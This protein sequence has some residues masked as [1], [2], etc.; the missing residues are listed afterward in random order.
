MKLLFEQNISFRLLRKIE[1]QYP[2]ARQV[3]EVGLEDVTD[4]Q[5]W[6]YARINKF[7][8]VTFDSDLFEIANLKEHP[9][10]IIW[11]RTGNIT[12]VNLEKVLL[13]RKEL[14]EDFISNPDYKSI[15]CLE[16][17]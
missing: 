5:I 3:K 10:K 6:E 17:D 16:I 1:G 11:L 7:T 8:I 13:K 12:T 2:Q 4:M 15:V 14:I 9:P